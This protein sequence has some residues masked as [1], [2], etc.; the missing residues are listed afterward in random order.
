MRLTVLG[1]G[2]LL[3]DDLRR[4]PAHWLEFGD[5][6][7]LLD[8][9]SG[10]LHALSRDRLWWKGLTHIALTHFH[11][12]HTGDLAALLFALKHGVRP[13]RTEP[14]TLLGPSGLRLRLHALAK[15]HGDFVLDPGFPLE[16][17]ELESGAACVA[18]D[19]SFTLRA[20]ATPHNDASL[21][22]RVD[23]AAGSVGYTGD[24]GPSV[25]LGTFFSG[26]DLLVSECSQPDPP[27][28]PTH[29][30]PLS[31]AALAS[32]AQPSL[33]VLTHLFPQLKAHKLPELVREAGYGGDV[34]V[35][36]D[37]M[38]VEIAGGEA[39]VV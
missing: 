22:Y 21:A 1:S 10:A 30:S 13:R 16:V 33:L 3:P 39:K 19:R 17:V 18:P 8:C 5:V 9:G 27:D 29:L 26:V 7:L 34:V 23:A 36:V 14:L 11:T 6:K 37:G 25:P 32:A 31:V 4:S 35:A 38:A 24:T 2:T 15:A 20:H 28:L 12:D